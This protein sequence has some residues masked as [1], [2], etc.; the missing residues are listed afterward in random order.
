MFPP[1][2]T[3]LASAASASLPLFFVLLAALAPPAHSQALY[4]ASKRSDMSAFAG[5]LWEHPDQGLV[6]NSG[7]TIGLNATHYFRFPIAPSLEVRANLG[8]G[9]TVTE[10]SLV[11]GIRA[12][13]DFRKF[14]PY[15]DFLIGPGSIRFHQALPPYT[16]YSTVRSFGG[17]F[18]YDLIGNFQAKVDFQMTH[19]NLGQ[20]PPLIFQPEVFTLGIAYR[21]PFRMYRTQKDLNP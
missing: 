5:F 20:K 9:S 18:D 16:D 19:W 15:G 4:T 1:K 3:S 7:A 10:R 14:H 17:G 13:S 6:N 8:M 21:F 12:Q 11:T 2:L